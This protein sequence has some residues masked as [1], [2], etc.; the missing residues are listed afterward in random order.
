MAQQQA[1][2]HGKIK[3][4][5]RRAKEV[6][7]SAARFANRHIVAG[8]TNLDYGLSKAAGVGDIAQINRLFKLGAKITA[9]LNG[10]T[11]LHYAAKHG[12]M[13]I[14]ILL[15]SKGADVNLISDPSMDSDSH[16]PRKCALSGRHKDIAGFLGV[17]ES[18]SAIS[19]KSPAEFL[20]S[21]RE[22]YS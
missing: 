8:G 2:K 18:L 15:I 7:I 11:A 19:K 6:L 9:D 22:C 16:T 5:R 20:K 12:H 4:F 17:M 13:K 1:E 10:K 14:C 3:A 21:F